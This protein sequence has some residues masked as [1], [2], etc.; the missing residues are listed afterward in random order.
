MSL[1]ERCLSVSETLFAFIDV[2]NLERCSQKGLHLVEVSLLARCLSVAVLK[3]KCF[4]FRGV[5]IFDSVCEVES[6]SSW[7]VIGLRGAMSG[8]FHLFF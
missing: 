5:V 6:C 2:S 1:L 3:N 4:Y 7:K 8:Y